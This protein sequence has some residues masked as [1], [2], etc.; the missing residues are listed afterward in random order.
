M[1]DTSDLL[2]ELGYTELLG[3]PVPVLDELAALRQ[4]ASD[5]EI[6]IHAWRE[7]DATIRQSAGLPVPDPEIVRQLAVARFEHA[8]S[9]R[10]LA[11]RVAALVA[12]PSDDELRE[13]IAEMS[14]WD[15]RRDGGR[16][17]MA[18]VLARHRRWLDSSTPRDEY[19][20]LPVAVVAAHW[21]DEVDDVLGP[22]PV[23]LAE[24]RFE[25]LR[26]ATAEQLADARP[27]ATDAQGRNGDPV[28]GS[29][30]IAAAQAALTRLSYLNLVRAA[31][32]RRDLP[33]AAE[34]VALWETGTLRELIRA[35]LPEA[36]PQP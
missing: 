10:E 26:A 15:R 27:F 22:V 30:S 21:V 34:L 16:H 4:R 3:W 36:S 20:G 32:K 17:P 19:T 6:G 33:G 13:S 11:G 28:S 12:P 31:Y 1:D 9:D 5:D 23:T 25:A 35:E 24:A 8:R 29:L 18:E 14:A 7:Q 2:P